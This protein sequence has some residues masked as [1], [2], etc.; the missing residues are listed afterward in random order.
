M[1]HSRRLMEAMGEGGSHN[2]VDF[3]H[4][5]LNVLD[6]VETTLT[7]QVTH[8]Q[9]A[10]GVLLSSAAGAGGAAASATQGGGWQALTGQGDR[11]GLGRS[12]AG[13]YSPT[14][15]LRLLAPPC[16]TSIRAS[17]M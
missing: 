1:G 15:S 10:L 8:V 16:A 6:V 3:A 7:D 17:S 13:A 5:S 2:R 11:G 9:R 14:R 12:R 4:T